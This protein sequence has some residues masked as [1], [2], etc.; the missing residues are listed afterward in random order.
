MPILL[1][2]Q[3]TK[4]LNICHLVIINIC[5]HFL[6]FMWFT[7]DRMQ[8]RYKARRKIASVLMRDL[9]F[10]KSIP[11]L[12]QLTEEGFSSAEHDEHEF[13]TLFGE[14]MPEHLAIA[15]HLETDLWVA[16]RTTLDAAKSANLTTQEYERLLPQLRQK[17]ATLAKILDLEQEI[18]TS[19]LH[20]TFLDRLRL[21][22][23]ERT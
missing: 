13:T 8:H 5:N 1:N 12:I 9:P 21:L 18:L 17:L 10:A 15:V 16:L 14:P 22:R 19:P 3:V 23:E 6:A 20:Q 4:L 11:A 2:R 7:K